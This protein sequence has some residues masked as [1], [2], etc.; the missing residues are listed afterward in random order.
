MPLR[1]EWVSRVE[2]R[3]DSLP[4]IGICCKLLVNW[5]LLEGSK[6]MEVIG[7]HVGWTSDHTPAFQFCTFCCFINFLFKK[8]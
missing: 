8:I 3:C 2:A 7:P 6:E 4:H 1:K 5:M